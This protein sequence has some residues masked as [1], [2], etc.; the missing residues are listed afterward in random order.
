VYSWNT[1]FPTLASLSW[2]LHRVKDMDL[3]SVFCMQIS[4]FSS[5][6]C[7]GTFVKIRWVHLGLLFYF[8]GLPV[9]FYVSTVL[10]LSHG[11]IV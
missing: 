10:F 3:V 11:S 6:I 8:T 4:S 9:Y 5:N 2:Y 7:L 1:L